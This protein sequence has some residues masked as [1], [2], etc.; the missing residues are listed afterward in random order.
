MWLQSIGQT[1]SGE[2]FFRIIAEGDGRPVGRPSEE[3][4]DFSTSRKPAQRHLEA[5]GRVE[6][7]DDEAPT[8]ARRRRGLASPDFA[9]R[10]DPSAR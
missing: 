7:R 1:M 10:E 2:W 3:P 4:A 9:I 6:R 8:I 5:A